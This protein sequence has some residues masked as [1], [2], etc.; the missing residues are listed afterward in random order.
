MTITTTPAQHPPN[1]LPK[2]ISGE[3]I[4]FFIEKLNPAVAV[5]IHNH[6]WTH[7]KEN[8]E[9]LKIELSNADINIGRI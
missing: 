9:S 7:F 3:V 5:P 2:F 4:G 1:W 6:G 8:N